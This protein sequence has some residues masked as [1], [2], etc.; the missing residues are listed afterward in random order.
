[1]CGCACSNAVARH[2]NGQQQHKKFTSF[3]FSLFKFQ[4]FP[5]RAKKSNQLLA[6]RQPKSK[7]IRQ[8]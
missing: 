2:G 1:M 6:F 4:K 7:L 5:G 3:I 8:I